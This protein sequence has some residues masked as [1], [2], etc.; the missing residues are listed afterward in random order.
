MGILIILFGV[1]TYSF[2]AGQYQ[3]M[4]QKI[5]GLSSEGEEDS[6]LEYFFATFDHF[7]CNLPFDSIIKNQIQQFLKFKWENDQ[8]NFLNHAISN[9][10]LIN[11]PQSVKVELF[12][13]FIFKD[14]I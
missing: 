11:L 10:M 5:I 4:L 14:F 13:K 1:A 12:T 8:V 2:I 9:D 3:T 7:N 6:K